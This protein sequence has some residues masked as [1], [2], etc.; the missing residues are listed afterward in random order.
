MQNSIEELAVNYC[1]LM[2]LIFV[3]GCL[4]NENIKY[5]KL[6]VHI[7]EIENLK[8][9]PV[10][11]ETPYSLDLIKETVFES[12]DE[13][14]FGGYISRFAIDDNDR[15]YIAVVNSNN[16]D[17]YIFEPDGSFL[18]KKSLKGRGAGE[19]ESITSLEIWNNKLLIFGANLQKFVVF[20]IED[21][22]LIDENL[23]TKELI[24]RDDLLAST[25][26]GYDM[27]V[28]NQGEMFIKLTSLSLN[29][30]NE[31]AKVLY[32]KVTPDGSILPERI[33]EMDD[34]KLLYPKG[35][36][37]PIQMPFI[38]SQRVALSGK[39]FFYTVWTE[40][41]LVK[42]FDLKG[43]YIGAYYYPVEKPILDMNELEV[44][45]SQ[46]GILNNYDLPE[47]WQAVGT[48]EVDN[49]NRLWVSTIT[50]SNR[51]FKWWVLDHSGEIVAN[52]TLEGEGEG[53]RNSISPMSTPLIKIKDDHFYKLERNIGKGTERIIK[54][55]IELTK[56]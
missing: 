54:Y 2:V 16:A 14:F 48:I 41:F 43:N 56:K 49:M 24:G 33:L 13:V 23:L 45:S 10:D 11:A 53:E 47:S 35:G 38:R 36:G 29:K 25:M 44:N 31:I 1:I 18:K 4:Q 17:L 21:F 52:F 27:K 9:F 7:N 28:N 5:S 30:Q 46:R 32:H 39:G 6:P 55:R 26:R 37:M 51:Q 50:E 19:F 20:S 34:F 3:T 12:T 22:N 8:L 15:V 40:D 42:R